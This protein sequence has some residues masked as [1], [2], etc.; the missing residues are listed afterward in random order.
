MDNSQRTIQELQSK[1]EHCEAETRQRN[2]E[3]AIL[4][5]V[6]EAMTKSLDVK[7][8]TRIVGDKV[9]DI[10]KADGV[11][12]MLLDS[13]TNLI[14]THYEYDKGEGGYIDYIEPFPLGKGLTTKIINSRQ[15]LLLNT[16]EE[17]TAHG[18]YIAPSQSREGLGLPPNHGS[19]FPS[20]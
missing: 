14:H 7:T 9:R 12:I 16:L 3:L 6:G 2:N 17:Q 8:M 15:P 1:L 20:P 4:N 18:G 11:S 19:G 13:K 5:S 10:L